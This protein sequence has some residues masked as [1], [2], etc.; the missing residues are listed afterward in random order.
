MYC[1]C[2]VYNVY[3][4]EYNND[5]NDQFGDPGEVRLK[6]QSYIQALS[7]YLVAFSPY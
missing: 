4:Y 5:D 2:K 6:S 3:N 7:L 1:M